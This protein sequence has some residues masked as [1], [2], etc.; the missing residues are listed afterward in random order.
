MAVLF[1]RPRLAFCT[2]LMASLIAAACSLVKPVETPVDKQENVVRLANSG[3][4]VEAAR[5]Y[6]ELASES[7]ADH[8]NYALLSAEQWVAA[9]NIVAAKQALASESSID[10]AKTVRVL[11]VMGILSPQCHLVGWVKV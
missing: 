10:A 8:D 6:D 11:F 2:F 1:R 3:K 5:A 7:P 9:G 4:H